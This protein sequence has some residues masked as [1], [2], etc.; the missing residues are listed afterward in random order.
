[1]RKLFFAA[2]SPYARKI[3]IIIAEKGLEAEIE[4]VARAPFEKPAD[5]VAL[6]PLSKIPTLVAE[7]GLVLFDS[8]V[9]AE[10]L[11]G[12]SSPRL[13]PAEGR[14]RWDSLRRQAL[15]DGMLDAGVSV[16]LEGRRPEGERSP[17]WVQRQ[18][19]AITRSLDAFEV[20]IG[21]FGE[22]LTIGHVALGCALGWL[23]FRLPQYDWPNS[24]PRLAGWYSRFSQRPSMLSTMP[25]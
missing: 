20:E 15:A 23:D 17:G 3:R 16:L 14:A 1:M 8:P 11:D 22:A 6:N 25:E 5:L 4:M 18:T 21:A 12:I 10:Y 9:I 7:D 2:P 19:D 24:H 13:I